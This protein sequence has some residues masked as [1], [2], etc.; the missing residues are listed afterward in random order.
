MAH[1][2]SCILDTDQ[3]DFSLGLN[4]YIAK[5]VSPQDSNESVCNHFNP[6]PP[7]SSRLLPLAKAHLSFLYS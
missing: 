5:A 6:P 4:N 3:D 2:A 1:I 7:A